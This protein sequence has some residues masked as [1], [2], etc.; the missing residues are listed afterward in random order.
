M[1]FQALSE[2]KLDLTLFKL[3]WILKTA[4]IVFYSAPVV[5]VTEPLRQRLFFGSLRPLA[6]HGCLLAK[7]ADIG[8][9]TKRA[10]T[11]TFLQLWQLADVALALHAPIPSIGSGFRWPS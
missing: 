7:R 2:K 5:K 4:H 11:G 3:W 10:S 8:L 1:S 9:S 6:R